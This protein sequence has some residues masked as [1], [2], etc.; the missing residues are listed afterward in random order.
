MSASPGVPSSLA[1]ATAQK[2][3]FRW[4]KAL[5]LGYE[6]GRFEDIVLEEPLCFHWLVQFVSLPAYY[7]SLTLLR[8]IIHSGKSASE[9]KTEKL[10]RCSKCNTV[11]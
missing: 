9:A 2:S 5:E 10:S 11:S 8:V 1:E 7:F 6:E 4:T 3:A